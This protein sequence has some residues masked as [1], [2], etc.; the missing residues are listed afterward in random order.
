MAEFLS[1]L[2][3][4]WKDVVTVIGSI[5]GVG[6]AVGAFYRNRERDTKEDQSS[7]LKA[8]DAL[9]SH[10]RDNPELRRIVRP[11][12]DV[13][14]EPLTAQEEV[15]LNEVFLHFERGWQTAKENKILT[16]EAYIADVRGFFSLPLPRIAWEK[17]KAFRNPKFVKFVEQTITNGGQTRQRPA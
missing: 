16:M 9:W 12:V 8:H 14:K 1:W 4:N 10:V 3:N 15:F 11:D 5:V 6:L 17:R 7:L 13:S 2:N